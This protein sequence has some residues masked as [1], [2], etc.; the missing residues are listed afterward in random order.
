MDQLRAKGESKIVHKWAKIGLFIPLLF[1]A[2]WSYADEPVS[3]SFFGDKAINGYDTAADHTPQAIAKHKAV[4][5]NSDYIVKWKGAKW[6]FRSA[7][8]AKKFRENPIRYSPA[9]NGHCANALSLNEGLVKTDG[10]HWEIL[11]EKLY[12][13]YAARGR[14]R[15]LDG[16]WKEY[17]KV[18]DSEWLRLTRH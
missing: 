16:N 15:W 14:D 2:T 10:T 11:E 7:E 4:K 1:V 3:K 8:S 12:L 5:G 18:A 6:H 13:F 17:K 9:Y